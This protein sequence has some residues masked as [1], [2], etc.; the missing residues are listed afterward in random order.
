MSEQKKKDGAD[1]YGKTHS[2]SIN[3]WS[4]KEEAVEAEAESPDLPF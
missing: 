2:V 4:P 1:Q 3:T